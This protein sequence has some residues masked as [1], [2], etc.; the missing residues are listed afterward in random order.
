MNKFS[1]TGICGAH[2]RWR[3]RDTMESRSASPCFHSRPVNCDTHW[4]S[5]SRLLGQHVHLLASSGRLDARRPRVSGASAA[6]AVRRF[7]SESASDLDMLS[8]VDAKSRFKSLPRREGARLQQL[9]RK[10]N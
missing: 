4:T 3:E 7:I 8:V 6:G 5:I 9:I 1:S 10:V 2:S